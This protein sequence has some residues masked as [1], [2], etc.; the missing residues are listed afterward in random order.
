L[1]Y[2]V[3]LTG[4]SH[5][6]FCHHLLRDD[7]Q[8][9]VCFALWHPSQGSERLTAVVGNPILPLSGER[10]VHGNASFEPAYF[11]RALGL[12]LEADAG[13]ALLHS[14]P[15]GRGWQGMSTDDVDAERGHAPQTFGA[16][17]LPLVGLTLAGDES[18]SARFWPRLEPRRYERVDCSSVRVLADRLSVSW[19]DA[20]VPRPSMQDRQIRTI[21]A[22][23]EA[24]QVDLA[25][26]RIGVVGAGSVG[27]L[28]AEALA[29]TG[30]ERIRLVDFDTVEEHN[31][32]RLLHATR[33]DV[34]LAR[35]KVETLAAALVD[36][37]T[38]ERPDIEPL[39]LSV[40]E[41]EGWRAALDCDV[42]FSCVDRPW[43][44]AVLNMAAY[45]HLIPV[46]DGGIRIVAGPR[47]LVR[48]DWRAHVVAPGRRCLECLGQY[49]PADVQMERDGMLDDP[50]YISGLPENHPLRT[51]QNVF[52]FSLAVSSLELLQCLSMLIA[53]AGV[54]DVGAQVFHFVT[55]TI[56]RDSEACDEACFYSN[57]L[58]GF[59]DHA[60][61]EVTGRHEVAEKERTRRAAL[62]RSPRVRAARALILAAD[63]SIEA[64][65]R[66]LLRS[67]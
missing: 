30:I 62:Q 38:A 65:S 22:W 6:A 58:V 13:L 63:R 18:F 42:L 20:V 59:G 61:Y 36:S 51:R 12:A 31:L 60:P 1:T 29:R 15:G 8:E 67:T 33:L 52:A 44:R 35:S 4:E 55:G 7:G 25:R 54:A 53:P 48:A 10:S 24:A 45:A 50:S 41:P 5:A 23:G 66:A 11:E 3:A 16:L 28:V 46:V 26:L 19:N 40:V 39:E 56:D 34:A 27:A 9:D 37:S 21:S 64:S 49:D 57:S 17:G 2:S 14:H 47:G 32:D 43:A